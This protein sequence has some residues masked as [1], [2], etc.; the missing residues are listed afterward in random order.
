MKVSLYFYLNEEKTN[1]RT[2]TIP[3]YI[4]VR[5]NGKKAEGRLYH[6]DVLE[7]ERLFWDERTM[8]LTD[9]KHKSNKIINSVQKNLM[10]SSS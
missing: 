1:K 4:R 7:K 8:R 5:L 10:S 2:G 6:A 9:V 3:V